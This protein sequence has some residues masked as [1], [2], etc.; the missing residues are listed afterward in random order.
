MHHREMWNFVR[1]YE[2]CFWEFYVYVNRVLYLHELSMKL[3]NIERGDN[4]SIAQFYRQRKL[5]LERAIT[6]GAG[7]LNTRVLGKQ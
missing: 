4:S 3:S 1:P 6:A 2:K 7:T 5:E